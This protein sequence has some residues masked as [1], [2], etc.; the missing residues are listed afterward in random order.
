MAEKPFSAYE[1]DQ[2]YFFVSYAHEDAQLVYPEMAWLNP[3]GFNL[4][5][6]DGIHV[7]SV[8]RQALADALTASA[9]LVFFATARS[10]ESSNCLKELNFILDDEKPV[11]VVQVDGTPL[12]SLLRLSLSDRQALVKSEYDEDTYRSRLIGALSTVVPP[13][14]RDVSGEAPR[15]AAGAIKTDP[16][17]IAVMPLTCLGDDRELTYLAQ[18]IVGDLIAKLSQR[19][20]HIVAGQPDD[21]ALEPHEIGE[22]RGVRYVLGGTL[23]RGGDRVRL[24]ARVTDTHNGRELWA[25]R[26]ERTGDDMLDMQ[27]QLVNSVDYEF[28]GA[29]MAA[30][31]E[32]LRDVP[33][34]EL[35]AWGL[36][37]R[38]RMPIVDRASRDRVR[39]LLEQ[40]VAR[41]PDFAFAHSLFAWVLTTMIYNQFTRK[42]EE[43]GKLALELAN[44]AL[45]LARNN[46][47]VLNQASMVHKVVGDPEHAVHLAERAAQIGGRA[48]P[49]LANALIGV[50]RFEDALTL[51]REEPDMVFLTDMVTASLALGRPEEALEWGRRATTQDPQG[52]LNWCHLA[53][54]QAE[55]G[56]ADAARASIERVKE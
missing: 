19:I 9:G 24:T 7:G 2:P 39:S 30:E 32:R 15:S 13:M 56:Q 54:A 36:C 17:S 31:N 14:V 10:T 23:Q 40:A 5:Y 43:D 47:V 22:R 34:A 16:P 35:D 26:Y 49:S 20:W 29:V 45:A 53:C 52:F 4:W 38:A 42:P 33:D 18:G 46:M 28:F 11:F 27:D 44:R 8:W 3:A 48:W 41:D 12:P 50:G 6:D 51:G 25:Q 1:G 55:L 37:A 21:V